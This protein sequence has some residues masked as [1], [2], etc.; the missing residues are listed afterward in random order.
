MIVYVLQFFRHAAEGR[1]PARR[2]ATFMNAAGVAD[3]TPP[4][5]GV[6]GGG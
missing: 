4:C 2:E 3:Q 6:E 1:H 5:G